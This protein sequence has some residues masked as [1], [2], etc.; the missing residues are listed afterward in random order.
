[1]VVTMALR[2]VVADSLNKTVL[3]DGKG[4][5]LT[6]HTMGE[7]FVPIYYGFCLSFDFEPAQA[8]GDCHLDDLEVRSKIKI[9]HIT[10][11]FLQ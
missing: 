8:E 3:K 9:L 10:R 4:Y 2:N 1:M 6:F 11:S 7:G 5:Y